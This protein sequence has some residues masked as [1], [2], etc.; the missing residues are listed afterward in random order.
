MALVLPTFDRDKMRPHTRRVV[1][2][3]SDGEWH[4]WDAVVVEAAALV[5]PGAAFRRS[6]SD[7]LRKAEYHG[8][9]KGGERKYGD[10][11]TAIAAGARAIV[12]DGIAGMRQR[13][14]VETEDREDGRWVRLKMVEVEEETAAPAPSN[15]DVPV[16]P[17][18]GSTPSTK[19]K[20]PRITVYPTNDGTKIHEVSCDICRI[21]GFVGSKEEA[22]LALAQHVQ[23]SHLNIFQAVVAYLEQAA[24]GIRQ[25]PLDN[26]QQTG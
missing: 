4:P 14:K 16:R 24:E 10:H 1:D 6:E 12:V 8:T 20:G 22:V 7:R 21:T 11:H 9:Y 26:V 5:P 2:L 19:Q 25:L 3:L 13:G 18:I 23:A 15:G 17:E